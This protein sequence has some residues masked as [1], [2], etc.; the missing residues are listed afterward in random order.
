MPMIRGR[1]HINPAMGQ[2]LEA[3]RE[4]EA[5]LRAL[6]PGRGDGGSGESDGGGEADDDFA[7]PRNAPS[8]RA[9]QAKGPIHRV[10]I[11]AAELAPAHSGRAMRGFVARVHRG[12]APASHGAPRGGAAPQAGSRPSAETH[13]FAHHGDL[14]NFLHDAFANDAADAD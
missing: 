7:P 1:Y 2:A 12:E 4:A 13:V 14:V 3:A 6:Q 9:A 8:A 5:A 11:E 10:E